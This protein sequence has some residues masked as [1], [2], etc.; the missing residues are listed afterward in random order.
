MRSFVG[1]RASNV[2]DVELSSVWQEAAD[3]V[4]AVTKE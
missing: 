3:A 1:V 2:K 4:L